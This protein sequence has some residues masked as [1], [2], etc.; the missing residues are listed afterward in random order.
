MF[1]EGGGK[2]SIPADLV[3]NLTNLKFELE[4]KDIATQRF[5]VTKQKTVQ[6][7]FDFVVTLQ[8]ADE[9]KRRIQ[10]FLSE[11][12]RNPPESLRGG[13]RSRSRR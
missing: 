11:I 9:R 4:P 10:G 1:P 12:A 5:T 3:T 7:L 13:G 8:I 6:E 2:G